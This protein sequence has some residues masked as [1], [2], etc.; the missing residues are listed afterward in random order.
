MSGALFT[1]DELR[2]LRRVA[3][4]ELPRFVCE[5]DAGH[6]AVDAA[7]LRGLA[8]RGLVTLEDGVRVGGELTRLLAPC[9]SARLLAEV[10]LE[11]AGRLTHIALAAGTERVTLLTE[12]DAGL[13]SVERVDADPG[14]VLARVCRL[15]EVAEV[16][17]GAGFTV[18]AEAHTEADGLV[19]DGALDAAARLLTEA[20]VQASSARAWVTAVAGRRYAASLSVARRRDDGGPVEA[21]ELRWLVAGDGT[22]W[23]V[24]P[25]EPPLA[26]WPDLRP[27][28][29][30][31]ITPAGRPE[32]HRD[33]AALAAA[34]TADR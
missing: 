31:V 16:G 28:E 7:A 11:S 14:E 3:E 25:A 5:G 26:P 24:E 12:R 29:Y 9:S 23:R 1:V 22:A 4:I 20:G 13:V 6:V 27:P 19:L 30:A 32:L 2:A 8:V 33:L 15:D 17:A 10:E 21:G 18:A 34:E